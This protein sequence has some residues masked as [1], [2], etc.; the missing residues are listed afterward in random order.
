MSEKII[1]N[2]TRLAKRTDATA[3][4]IPRSLALLID[5]TL[6][7]IPTLLV[8][9]F[10]EALFATIGISERYFYYPKFILF[11]A[12]WFTYT[13]VMYHF[14]GATLGK[15]ALGLQVVS[16]ETQHLP[17]TFRVFFREV[18]AR[19]LSSI[20][21]F[22]YILAIFRHDKKSLHD[23]LAKTE[24]INRRS[25]LENRDVPV[26]YVPFFI[27]L[28][29]LLSMS[30]MFKFEYSDSFNKIQSVTKFDLGNFEFAKR[31]AKYQEEK[32][33][34]DKYEG[35]S[36]ILAY[37]ISKNPEL[38]KTLPKKLITEELLLKVFKTNPEL[39]S[40]I[41]DDFI[42]TQKFVEDLV[43]LLDSPDTYAT[44]KLRNSKHYTDAVYK[45]NKSIEDE[46]KP[47]IEAYKNLRR[48]SLKEKSLYTIPVKILRHEKFT[49]FLSKTDPRFGNM[50]PSDAIVT[51]EAAKEFIKHN[52]LKRLPI[53]IQKNSEALTFV[54][55]NSKHAY[56]AISREHKND[57]KLAM[58]AIKAFPSNIQ[59]LKGSLTSDKDIFKMALS[60]W[61]YSKLLKDDHHTKPKKSLIQY[62]I[63]AYSKKISSY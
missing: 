61:D 26:A 22:G 21:F 50:L 33:I 62:L 63:Q 45:K 34:I 30:F 29:A 14:T 37:D 42:Y 24:V 1:I 51:T 47:Y 6:I 43:N 20:F 52:S 17:S 5:F 9:N 18:I 41:P 53:S 49:T 2:T 31:F 10:A 8:L 44:V 12:V 60:K 3:G 59:Y 13:A 11:S 48:P 56:R 36:I 32:E 55:T 28:L 58:I 25:K 40:K 27:S 35:N 4:Y 19:P 38:F 23:I 7:G 15:S 57:K 39:M 54:L 46:M 16:T